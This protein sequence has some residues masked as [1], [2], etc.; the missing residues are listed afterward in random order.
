MAIAC[1]ER[2]EQAAAEKVKDRI[3]EAEKRVQRAVE[4]AVQL[5][6]KKF[7]DAMKRMEGSTSTGMRQQFNL[8][9]K[10]LTHIPRMNGHG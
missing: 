6:Q 8:E 3:D 7:T 4:S 10:W 9:L 1:A 2:A 5:E